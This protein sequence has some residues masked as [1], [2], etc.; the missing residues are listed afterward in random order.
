MCH[1]KEFDL[2]YDCLT[3]YAVHNRLRNLKKTDPEFWNELTAASV[4]EPTN[5]DQ[6]FEEDNILG[7]ETFFDDDCN[8]KCD[9]VIAG[10]TGLHLPKD[11]SLTAD[12]NLASVAQAELMEDGV[13]GGSSE[14]RSGVQPAAEAEEALGPGK[15]KRRPNTLYNSNIFWH[16]HDNEDPNDEPE[17]SG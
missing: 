13:D 1:V 8:L 16:H 2:S 15:R 12:G 7:P 5:D 9:T 4:P 14:P 17:C 10:V 3:G 11:V 6:V